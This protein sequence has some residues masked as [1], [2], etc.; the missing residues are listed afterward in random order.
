MKGG[1]DALKHAPHTTEGQSA[2]LRSVPVAAWRCAR[3]K[4]G[5]FDDEERKVRSGNPRYES[6]AGRVLPAARSGFGTLINNRRHAAAVK[7]S[8]I[9]CGF[10]GQKVIGTI[11][12]PNSPIDR[13]TLRSR[14]VR[15]RVLDDVSDKGELH[16]EK[17]W[18]AG[19][20]VVVRIVIGHGRV[21]VGRVDRI[22]PDIV[23]S[24]FGCQ[25]AHQ[26]VH[27]G[28]GCRVVTDVEFGGDS[29]N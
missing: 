2:T 25:S 17:E 10:W 15:Q 18:A 7:T 22:D 16:Q 19:E 24:E 14:L 29:G 23:G 1:A 20:Q 8:A 6:P 27:R 11:C 12:P 4:W 28:L 21:H 9:A 26:A 3:R 13:I 5:R